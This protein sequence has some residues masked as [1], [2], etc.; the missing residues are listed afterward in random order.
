LRVT[1]ESAVAQTRIFIAL[2][3]KG[4]AGSDGLGRRGAEKSESARGQQCESEVTHQD[5][6]SGA[7][8]SSPIL[9]CA[10][11]KPQR[12]RCVN[13]HSGVPD[14]TGADGTNS[15]VRVS[16]PAFQPWVVGQFDWGK[17]AGL[18]Y[19]SRAAHIRAV[20]SAECVAAKERPMA[21]TVAKIAIL[22]VLVILTFGVFPD[23]RRGGI[24]AIA[25]CV[26]AAFVLH[27]VAP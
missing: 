7:A 23:R 16:L 11:P 27:F 20:G 18:D 19:A 26:A 4:I 24:I 15:P 2:D 5:L 8:A 6:P 25:T 3:A 14:A 17:V 9:C 10:Q 21:L 22:A 13:S 1:G 12:R